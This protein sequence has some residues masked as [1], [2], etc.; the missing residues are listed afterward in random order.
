MLKIKDNSDY[1]TEHNKNVKNKSD[2][3]FLFET[4]EE[5]KF[6]CFI[7]FEINHNNN[8]NDSRIFLTVTSLRGCLISG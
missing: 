4:D 8:K 1:S 2:L 5:I 6:G 7:S 3:I